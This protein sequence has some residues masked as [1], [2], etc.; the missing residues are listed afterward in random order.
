MPNQFFRAGKAFLVFGATALLG[1]LVF[2][3]ILGS[4]DE[5][6]Q[7]KTQDAPSNYTYRQTSSKGSSASPKPVVIEKIT[8]SAA[9]P[10]KTSDTLSLFEK[11]AS[12]EEIN[13]THNLGAKIAKE[14]IRRNPMGPGPVGAQKLEL[15]K[16]AEI[17]DAFIADALKTFDP[18]L[19]RP[20]ISRSILAIIPDSKEAFIAYFRNLQ[21][22]LTKEF[23]GV[24][25]GS[26]KDPAKMNFSQLLSTYSRAVDALLKLPVPETLAA[27]H[28]KE[29]SLVKGQ[30]NMMRLL[31]RYEEDP[32]R[33]Y[34]ALSAGAQLN[35][36]FAALHAAITDFISKN[37]ITI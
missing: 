2:L 8:V 12:A 21:N 16:P 20:D 11:N 19:F 17:V 31:S 15:A 35:E 34:V 23:A 30:A 32:L 1:V 33:A 3:F 10:A 4:I 5:A 26:L 18:K 7:F 6:R 9:A 36:E 27:I 22:I 24:D 29:I 14:I 37:S 28:Q 13:A 25:F